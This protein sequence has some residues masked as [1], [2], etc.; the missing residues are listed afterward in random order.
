MFSFFSVEKRFLD[1]FGIT[2]V[3]TKTRDESFRIKMGEIL[4]RLNA[5][6][7]VCSNDK[8]SGVNGV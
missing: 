6:L 7:K 4:I 3:F 1:A 2:P 8:L 5:S